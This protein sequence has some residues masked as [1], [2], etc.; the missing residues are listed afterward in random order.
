MASP[1]PHDLHNHFDTASEVATVSTGTT[2]AHAFISKQQDWASLVAVARGSESPRSPRDS[3]GGG[4]AEEER[5][6]RAAEVRHDVPVATGEPAPRLALGGF[7]KNLSTNFLLEI[8]QIF[9][10]PNCIMI[11]A[12][13]RTTITSVGVDPMI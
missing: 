12:K 6:A 13:K 7:A 4:E 11:C 2:A 5:V 8:S 10:R 1:S 3:L 9:H